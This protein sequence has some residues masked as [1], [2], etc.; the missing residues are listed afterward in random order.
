MFTRFIPGMAIL[1]VPFFLLVACAPQATVQTGDQI[2]QELDLPPYDGPP[3]HIAVGPCENRTG[4]SGTFTIGDTRISLDDEIGRGMGDMLVSALANTG[5]FAVV[6][7]NPEVIEAL[8]RQRA[9]RGVS[10]GT[11]GLASAEL[12]V[13]CGVTEFEPDASG[14]GG[15][16]ANVVGRTLAGLVGGTSTSRVGIDIRLVD[17]ST[18][19]VLNAF[20]VRGEARNVTM[21][22]LA[23]RRFGPAGALGGFSN[24]PIEEAV[25]IAL[26]EAVKEIAVR[27]P[28]DYFGP[29]L[30]PDGSDAGR[31]H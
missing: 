6:E 5:R 1:T 25:R 13:T 31:Y 11:A 26:L 23:A 30:E 20:T 22:G 7:A 10:E 15:G 12:M 19:L 4:G 14:I 16:A 28:D 3:A 2:A 24:T 21:G 9:L 18:G 29:S 8:E 27:T 17:V